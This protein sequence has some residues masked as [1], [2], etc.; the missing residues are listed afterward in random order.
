MRARSGPLLRLLGGAAVIALL[1][2]QVGTGAVLDGLAGLDAGVVLAA[3]ALGCLA[4]VCNAW[5]WCLVARGL[6]LR[7]SLPGAVAD[8]FQALFLNTALPAGVLGD[9]HRAVR[10]GRREGDLALGV[11]AV[12]LERIAGQVVLLVVAVGALVAEPALLRAIPV[13]G[14]GFAALAAG[15]MAAGW[16]LR[17]RL[18][19]ALAGAG[20]ALRPG[21]LALSA[22]ALAGCLAMFVLAARAAG[23]TAP[24]AVLLPLLV[25]ALLAMSLPLS[26]G[27][28]GPREA[29]AAVGFGV[30]GLGA[31]QGLATAVVYGVLGLLICLPGA[32]VL[33]VRGMR[34]RTAPGSPAPHVPSPPTPASVARPRPTP[35]TPAA[36]GSADAAGRRRARR[37]AAV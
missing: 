27:G 25:L 13:P 37:L 14:W 5:R 23:A 3:L 10:H 11:R 8:C 17:A 19:A 6:G 32:V 31:A 21:V 35:S 20:A 2:W 9:V 22:A 26:V 18:R 4:T 7:L 29:A 34:R 1:V 33:L 28:W 36:P 15:V 24:L 16:L 30:A 12:V